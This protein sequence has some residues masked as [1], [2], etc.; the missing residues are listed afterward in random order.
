MDDLRITPAAPALEA[1]RATL[2]KTMG[3]DPDD[4][5]IQREKWMDWMR[6]G[7]IVQ[8]HVSRWRAQTNLT[9]KVM[10][11]PMTADERARFTEIADLGTVHQLPLKT[12][13]GLNSLETRARQIPARHGWKTH[14]GW[15]IPADQYPAFR[16]E[17]DGVAVRYLQE[18]DNIIDNWDE[19]R[20]QHLRNVEELAVDAW[21]RWAAIQSRRSGDFL[22]NSDERDRYIRTARE[23]AERSLPEVSYVR[24]MADIEAELSYVPLPSLL[25]ADEADLDKINE[26]RQMDRDVYARALRKKEELWTEFFVDVSTQARQKVLD[27]LEAVRESLDRNEGNMHPRSL[28]SLRNLVSILNNMV[29][30]DDE[31]LERDMAAL[32]DICTDYTYGRDTVDVREV[33]SLLDDIMG[34]ARRVLTEV[35]AIERRARRSVDLDTFKV[36]QVNVERRSRTARDSDRP[37]TTVA[38][39]TNRRRGREL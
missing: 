16:A 4:I 30:W 35:G 29:F 33:E 34:N 28:D 38:P 37:V 8:V 10:G 14:W 36:E 12:R 11:L 39:T 6:E 32:E 5:T 3:V 15:F 20:E 26:L 24:N 13:R 2:A 27:V 1:K 19:Y 18:W 7:V 23:E 25:K 17:F 31:E 22:Y 21:D 9:F